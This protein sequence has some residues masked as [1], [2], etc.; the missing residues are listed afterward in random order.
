MGSRSL[1]VQAVFVFGRIALEL[2]LNSRAKFNFEV[3]WFELL[4]LNHDLVLS[5]AC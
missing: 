4:V 5:F 3:I 1:V 2:P